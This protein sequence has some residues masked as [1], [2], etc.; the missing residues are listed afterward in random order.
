MD[1]PTSPFETALC[2]LGRYSLTGGNEPG[3][4]R[5]ISA[6]PLCIDDGGPYAVQPVGDDG[7]SLT[8]IED[9]FGNVHITCLNGCDSD[10]IYAELGIRKPDLVA[11]PKLRAHEALE[12]LWLEYFILNLVAN[13]LVNRQEPLTEE[14]YERVQLCAERL[15]RV[16]CFY[17]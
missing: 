9:K 14:D 10:V 1:K 5:A 6:C 12:L 8:I 17:G 3:Q 13:K 15:T 2:K 16:R 4:R 7:P 11:K